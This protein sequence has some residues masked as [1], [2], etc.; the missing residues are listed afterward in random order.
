VHSPKQAIQRLWSLKHEKNIHAAGHEVLLIYLSL[1]SLDVVVPEMC[2][3]EMLGFANDPHPASKQLWGV[4]RKHLLIAA[5]AGPAAQQRYRALTPAPSEPVDV[6]CDFCSLMPKF[7]LRW[8][9]NDPKSQYKF[10]A[11]CQD[12]AVASITVLWPAIEACSS[13]LDRGEWLEPSEV[14]DQLNAVVAALRRAP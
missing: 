6:N 1:P 10:K 9:V 8:F 4:R 12:E 7:L 3:E 5:L 11:R 14:V 13:K 2:R